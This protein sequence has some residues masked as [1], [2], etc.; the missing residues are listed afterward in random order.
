MMRM[1]LI[2]ALI[3]GAVAAGCASYGGTSL[4]PGTSTEAQARAVMGQPAVEFP[5]GDGSRTL[6]YPRGPLGTQTFMVDLSRDG[7]VQAVRP[8]LYDATFYRIQPGMTRDDVLRMIG[9]P[10]D[11]MH[12]ARLD[13]ESWEWRY[14]DTWGY[15]AIF[16]VDFDRDGKVVSKFSRRLERSDGKSR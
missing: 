3:A 14:Y 1:K 4:Q 12:F 10:G 13:H 5:N 11:T 2:A 8:V 15:L 6:A 16:S 7:V 9:P